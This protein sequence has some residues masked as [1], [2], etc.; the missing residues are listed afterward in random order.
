MKH[1][2]C[3]RFAYS[4]TMEYSVARE[5]AIITLIPPCKIAFV[6]TVNVDT[7]QTVT[8]HQ[9]FISKSAR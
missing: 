6:S 8:I 4:L 1:A 9:A 7:P 2:F 5:A 3:L